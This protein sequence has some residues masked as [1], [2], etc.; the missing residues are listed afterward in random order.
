[1]SDKFV[2]NKRSDL[3]FEFNWPDGAGGNA[4]LNGYVL[5]LVDL[6]PALV[7]H[8]TTEFLDIGQGLIKTKIQ[9]DNSFKIG[10]PMEFRFLVQLGDV[11]QSS[12]SLWVEFE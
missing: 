7:G 5:S 4:N 1:M 3:E 10:R 11:D 9:W 8:I 2:V 6:D 12:N